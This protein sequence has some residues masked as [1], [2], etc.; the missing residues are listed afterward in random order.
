MVLWMERFL[1]CERRRQLCLSEGELA[2]DAYQSTWPHD[3]SSKSLLLAD[4][5]FM[6]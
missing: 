1:M 3:L 5:I 6:N 2:L 4:L